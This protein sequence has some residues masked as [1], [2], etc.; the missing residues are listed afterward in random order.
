MLIV[1]LGLASV[2]M[3]YAGNPGRPAPADQASA[4]PQ[5]G[6][7]VTAARA[8]ARSVPVYL[9]GLGTVQ[10]FNTVSVKSRV[11]GQIT[12]VLFQ[13]G[14]EVKAGD[15]LFQIDPRPFQAAL[16]QAQATKQKDEAQLHSAQLDLQRYQKLAPT[17]FQTQQQ[18][19]Q[20]TG[21]VGQLQGA[22][23]ADQAQID[24]AQLNL[25]YALIRSPIEGRTGRRMVDVGNV[26][27]S[28]Q[29]TP[30]VA[31][32]QLRPI[33]VTFNV[34]ADRLG[35]IRKYQ[36]QG[37][38]TVVAYALDDKTEIAQGKLTLINN[39]VDEA[40]DTVL[41]KAQFDNESEP[42]WPGESVN[43]HLILTMEDNAVTVPP[44]TVMQGPNGAYVYVLGDN[45]T[46]HRRDVAV[47]Q[48]QQGYSVITNGLVAGDRVVV[49]GQY[50]LT[51]GAKARIGEAQPGAVAQKSAP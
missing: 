12:R 23:K 8:E 29:N 33:F 15:P 36:M 13:E 28:A 5:Q 25:D 9:E 11:D 6:V 46:A 49:E 14:Q 44:Q 1:L 40:T 24:N 35:E 34:P 30:L 19:D 42:L 31:I 2:L 39:Q 20:Q 43:A 22:V 45:D 41:L 38:L 26:V 21:L 48:T 32:A 16:A 18:L 50:R 4:T 27:Q 3:W 7:P 37:P 17:G 47:A 10:A 51:D